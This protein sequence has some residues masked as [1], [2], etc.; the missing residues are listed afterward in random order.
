MLRF[1]KRR[2]LRPKDHKKEALARHNGTLLKSY[3]WEEREVGTE[4]KVIVVECLPSTGKTPGS[5]TPQENQNSK[6][7][8]FESLPS[9]RHPRYLDLEPR[10]SPYL[11]SGHLTDGSGSSS[12]CTSLAPSS[13]WGA[14][15]WELLGA[16]GMA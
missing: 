8:A 14:P 11:A 4:F 15:T 6:N 5:E 2:K 10:R 7:L 12:G 16:L 9:K 13:I 1:F 3:T